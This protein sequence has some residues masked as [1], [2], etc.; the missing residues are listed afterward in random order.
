MKKQVWDKDYFIESKVSNYQNYLAKKYEGL[1]N[2]LYEH[3]ELRPFFKILDFGC[4]T[5]AL[6]HELKKKGFENLKGTDISHWAIETGRELYGFNGEI[7]HYN[8]DLLEERWNYIFCLD[9]LEHMP[10]YEIDMVLELAKRKLDGYFVMRVPVSFRE[11][12]NYYLECSRVDKTHL[13]C[14]SR[15]WWLKKFLD[16]GYEYVEDLDLDNIYSSK[17]VFCGVFR[18]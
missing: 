12:E 17:G 14:H 13:Q 2:D 10:E 9:V 1:A 15:E 16:A 5:G 18:A 4:G 6:I 11:G 8:R 7:V 3:F